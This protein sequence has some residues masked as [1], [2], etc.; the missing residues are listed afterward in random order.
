ML[1]YKTQPKNDTHNHLI[2]MSAKE[3]LVSSLMEGINHRDNKNMDVST[4]VTDA[5]VIDG[6]IAQ[7]CYENIL[8]VTSPI[9]N[10]RLRSRRYQPI[11]NAGDLLTPVVHVANESAGKAHVTIT[12]DG[13]LYSKVYKNW[14]I[15]MIPIEN[16]Y[17][18]GSPVTVRL[19]T[20]V[21]FDAVVLLGCAGSGHKHNLADVKK[22]FA[23]YCTKDFTL[24]DVHR[25]NSR[26]IRGKRLDL[27]Q[28]IKRYITCVNALQPL[29]NQNLKV[30]LQLL[31]TGEKKAKEWS[32][33]YRLGDNI[34]NI[35][36]FYRVYK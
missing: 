34:Q 26:T 4:L 16:H 14:D 21:K 11:D 29:Y 17:E 7:G 33:Y 8:F 32:M 35:N 2:N 20:S 18:V 25:K 3:K 24:I 12:S 28:Q 23:K 30:P 15:P 10:D 5:S 1:L 9:R 31:I 22:Q 13:H 19:K 27:T 36:E 6:M